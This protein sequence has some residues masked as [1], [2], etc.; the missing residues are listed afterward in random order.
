[1]FLT[2]CCPLASQDPALLPS[3]LCSSRVGVLALAGFI[4]LMKS[5]STVEAY[6]VTAIDI[7]YCGERSASQFLIGGQGKPLTDR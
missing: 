2:A 6:W 3:L 5:A 1:M 4:S 7:V